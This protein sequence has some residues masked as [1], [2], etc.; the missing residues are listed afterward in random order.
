[1]R[2]VADVLGHADV[3]VTLNTYASGADEAQRLAVA[4]LAAGLGLSALYPHPYPHHGRM[5]V[6][7]GGRLRTSHSL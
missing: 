2:T 6:R 5:A 3:S 1:M 7:R 4:G